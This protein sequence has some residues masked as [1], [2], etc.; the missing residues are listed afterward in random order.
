MTLNDRKK[1]Q[2]VSNCGR[3]SSNCFTEI[4]QVVQSLIKGRTGRRRDKYIKFGLNCCRGI[5]A[6]AIRDTNEF[7]WKF[8]EQTVKLEAVVQEV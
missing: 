3:Q 2:G 8:T 6:S 7:C 5:Q 4:I 1:I